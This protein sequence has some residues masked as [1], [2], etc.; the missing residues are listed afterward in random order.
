LAGDVLA[1]VQVHSQ[2]LSI[3]DI[4]SIKSKL[5]KVAEANKYL[6]G[7][8]LIPFFFLL[9]NRKCCQLLRSAQRIERIIYTAC[10]AQQ[11]M[12]PC[13]V[14]L[15]PDTLHCEFILVLE[16]YQPTY[17][18]LCVGEKIQQFTSKNQSKHVINKILMYM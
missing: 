7:R 3:E 9:S 5:E 17:I 14:N 16:R 18:Y 13:V 2:N 4:D 12:N 8:L 15:F 10:N 6:R 11:A 1:N